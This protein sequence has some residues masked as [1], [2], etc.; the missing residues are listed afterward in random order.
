V[1]IEQ[2]IAPDR[3]A[4]AANAVHY[5]GLI[6]RAIAFAVDA[7]AINVVAI[8]V[9]AAVGVS[10][11]VLKVPSDVETALYALGGVSYLLWSLGYFVTFWSTT[12]QTPGN[13]LL[14]VRVVRED[15]TL[16]R[17]ARALL[18]LAALV[19]AAVPLFAGFVPVLFDDRRRGVHDMI[20]GTV[21]VPGPGRGTQMDLSLS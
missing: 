3:T 9:G 15:G 10:L 19:L 14:G 13:R 6:T 8:V 2:P 11:S 17:P 12:G 7:T 4:S 16:L 20:A 1:V 5:E 18:R 21:V